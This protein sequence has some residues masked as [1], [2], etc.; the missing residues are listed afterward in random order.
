MIFLI[1]LWQFLVLSVLKKKK[2]RAKTQIGYGQE[3]IMKNASKSKSNPCDSEPIEGSP[4]KLFRNGFLFEFSKTF[5]IRKLDQL[6]RWRTACVQSFGLKN[7]NRL[8]L[9]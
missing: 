8:C 2:W 7:S 3:N 9:D 1:F 4:Y 5:V 6:I